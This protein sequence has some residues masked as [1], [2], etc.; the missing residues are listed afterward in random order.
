MEREPEKP[1]SVLFVCTLN[2]VRSPMAAAL[3]RRLKG[4]AIYV[5]SAGV[6][7]GAPDPC[8]VEV[9][10]EIGIALSNHHPHCLEDLQ[11][12]CFDLVVALTREARDRAQAWGRLAASRIEYWQ[13]DDPTMVE[14]TPEQRRAAYRSVRDALERR[15]AERFG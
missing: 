3:L 5:K 2:S 8:A 7:A 4:R 15:I 13:T 9:M 6:R 10:A 12:G 14:G 1:S 11:D